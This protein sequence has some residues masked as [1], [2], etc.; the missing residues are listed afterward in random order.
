M[1]DLHEMVLTW[2][3]LFLCLLTLSQL[4][5]HFPLSRPY[6][7]KE[8]TA[9]G[10]FDKV[11]PQ[12]FRSR[13][14]PTLQISKTSF[15][16]QWSRSVRLSEDENGFSATIRVPWGEKVLYRFIVD[17]R[18]TTLE[19]APTEVDRRGNINN[20]YYAPVESQEVDESPPESPGAS[21]PKYCG[22]TLIC[23]PPVARKVKVVSTPMIPLTRAPV[24]REEQ[25]KS[26]SGKSSSRK[27]NRFIGKPKHTFTLEEEKEHKRKKSHD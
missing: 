22:V 10:T 16:L 14:R 7:A 21:R 6:N 17:G 11:R 3:A 26:T 18:S 4:T 27:R 24:S 5:T 15:I 19:N 20:V 12:K 1:S 9:T 8:V 25:G 2:S 23:P 13:T